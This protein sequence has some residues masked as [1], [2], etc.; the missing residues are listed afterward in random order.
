MMMRAQLSHSRIENNKFFLFLHN[1]YTTCDLR[2]LNSLILLIFSF[3]VDLKKNYIL[4]QQLLYL[5]YVLWWEDYGQS[6]NRHYLYGSEFRSS[7]CLDRR[8]GNPPARAPST[9]L[10]A[11]LS[12]P[13]PRHHNA[14]S[15]TCEP[16]AQLPISHTRNHDLYR[17]PTDEFCNSDNCLCK[18]AFLDY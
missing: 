4:L 3:S 10:I 9:R 8:R 1:F 5:S 15:Y 11:I 6:C 2:K 18:R 12:R 13:S 14:S 17:G 16:P 7:S